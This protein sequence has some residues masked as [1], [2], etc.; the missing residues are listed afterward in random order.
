MIR[1]FLTIVAFSI[2]ANISLFG[3]TPTQ[4]IRGTVIDEDT[5]LPL[6]GATVSL[7]DTEPLIGTTT[8]AEGIFRLEKIPIGRVNLMISYI[9]YQDYIISNIEVNSAKEIILEIALVESAEALN[10][11]IVTASAKKGT[12]LNE[13][14]IVSARSISAEQTSRYAGGFNDPAKITGNF[15]G[16]TNSQD[17][18]ND[19]IIRGNSPKYV[20]WRLEGVE[21][22][23][24]NHFGDPSSISGSTGALNNNLLSTSDFY[25][26]AFPAEFGDALSGVYDVRM[27]RGNNEKFEGIF[28]FGLLG[29]EA[30]VEGPIKKGYNGSYLAN[31]RYSTIGAL[32]ELGVVPVED[33]DLK[34]QDAAFKIYLPTKKFGTFS[35]FGLQGN[36]SFTFLDINPGLIVT[37]GNDFAQSDIEEDF[38][39]GSSLLNIGV[40]HIINIS[41]KSYFKTSLL[42]SSEGIQ[43]KVFEN[44]PSIDSIPERRLNFNSDLKKNTYK[45]NTQYKHKI[46]AKNKFSA[47]LQFALFEQDLT[48]SLLNESEERQALVDF[49]DNITSLRSFVNWK[50]IPTNKLSFVFGIH[51]T[52]IFFNNKF[53]V[54]PRLATKYSLTNSSSIN[55]GFGL[56]SRMESIHNYFAR[57]ET[58][59]GT[60][61]TPNLN[62]GL[63]K[64]SHYVIGYDKYFSKNLRLKLEVYFQDLYNVPVENNPNSTY[65]TLN[66]GLELNYVDLI[67]EGTGKNYGVELT[68]ERFLDNGLYFLFNTSLFES[69]Y[70]A[71]DG[72]ERDT[73]FN[74]NYIFNILA[75]KE[76]SRLGKKKNQVFAINIKML[77]G[78]GRYFI[79]LLRD[80]DGNLAVDADK[81]LIFDFDQAYAN[82]LDDIRNITLSLSYKWNKRKTT[83]ELFLNIDNMTNNQARLRAYYDVNEPGGIAY[84]KQVGII[85]NFLYRIYF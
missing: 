82:K 81:G 44:I 22:T 39:K 7:L 21:I 72:V 28:G 33:V 68:L 54:E 18:G 65:A 76:F 75:G 46:N 35:I 6:L 38:D 4:L 15:A 37:P 59:D 71:L 73:K 48:Q 80:S 36:S 11:V 70:T 51:N 19:I 50:Y 12:A 9:G 77:L 30:T 29:T 57:V 20:G 27:R 64:A 67:N 60:I 14:A 74:G 45:L 3:Q 62:L 32:L 25:T 53:T 66:E 13:S 84:E 55:F 42:F 41:P 56:H 52:N 63:I 2:A 58:P 16:V 47:G 79:P 83:H 31:F 24:P 1:T 23:N 34:F 61:T 5:Q 8:D 49:K 40:N 10:E 69:K 43:D 78:G 17:G 26:G 85:P